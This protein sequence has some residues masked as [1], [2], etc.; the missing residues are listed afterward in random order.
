MADDLKLVCLPEEK[1]QKEADNGVE[2]L[3]YIAD[4]VNAYRFP[5][6]PR[7]RC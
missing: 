6:S 1:A 2:Q 4:L 3:D 7:C 5:V